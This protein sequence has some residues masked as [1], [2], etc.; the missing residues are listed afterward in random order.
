MTVSAQPTHSTEWE[1]IA[2]GEKQAG[3]TLLRGHTE[4]PDP[5]G[6]RG[7]G[8]ATATWACVAG[9]ASQEA[10]PEGQVSRAWA[11]EVWHQ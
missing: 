3:D 8:T 2:S 7:P 4:L 11:P 6:A 10:L 1:H 5:T 9:A